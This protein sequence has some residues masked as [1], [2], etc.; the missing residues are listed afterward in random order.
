MR[1]LKTV[2]SHLFPIG[3][4]IVLSLGYF[5]PVLNGKA[6]FQ[7]D[8]V[9]FKGMQ[10]QVLEHR[11]DFEEEPYWIDNAFGG[12]PTYQIVSKHAHDLIGHI[13]GL[14]RFLPRPADY[15][16]VYLVGFYFLALFF[17]ASKPTAVMGAVAFGFSTYLIIILGVGHNTKALAIGYMPWA[18]LGV[19]HILKNNYTI[20]FPLA[21]LGTA[22]QLHANH[23]QMTY[24]MLLLMGVLVLFHV[25]RH[26]KNNSLPQLLRPLSMLVLSF[27]LALSFNATHLLAT[28]EYTTYST[29]G[30]NPLTIRADG[31]PS[32]DNE[33]LSYEYI[34]EYSY[35]ILESINLLVP[36]FMG[37]G[38]GDRLPSDSNL[39]QF[40]QKLEP[41]T[42]QQIFRYATPYWGNQPIVEAPAYVGAVV[43]FLALF[44]FLVMR[45]RWRMF[46]LTA[47]LMSLFLSWGKNADSLTHF[48]I[49][50]LPF[51]NKFRAV[52]SAQVILELCLPIAA[53]LGV[54]ALLNSDRQ[55]QLN[56]ALNKVFIG[57]M[58]F[59]GLILI[60]SYTLF[61][62]QSDT[63]AF[64]A[65]PEIMTPLVEDRKQLMMFDT[66]RSAAF[67]FIAF[68]LCRF[69]VS[70][71]YKM[72]VVP[73]LTLLI[74][75]DLWSF[76]RNYVNQ[77]D[78][79]SKSRI[80][81]PFVATAADLAIQRDTT[82]FRVFEPQLR[83]AHSRTAY[84]HNTLGGYHGAK[85]R[86]M[87]DL[88]DFH[89]AKGNDQ[90]LNML[91]VKYIIQEDPDNPLGVVRNPDSFGNAW[92]V[93]EVVKVD[94][95]ND[96][97]VGLQQTSLQT[98]ALTTDSLPQYMFDNDPQASIKLVH[99][100]ANSLVYEFVGTKTQF[101]VFSE[102]YYPHGWQAFIDGKSTNHYRVNYALRG[103][104]IPAGSSQITFKF[105]P[106][107]IQTGN[108]IRYTGY[109]VFSL[110]LVLLVFLPMFKNY[111]STKIG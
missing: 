63:E 57:L 89:L 43:F 30:D 35:G 87:Q 92:L 31:T 75:I 96:E 52:S 77:D 36:R 38:S 84:F 33:G 6:I 53:V 70:T 76:D 88:Y 47:S 48:L 105:V 94:S 67:V 10:R 58:I 101:A 81:Q 17:K 59:L 8:I 32:A 19:L 34:T 95:S 69:V 93:Q 83:M 21:V 26:I 64:A 50:Y 90:V 80:D 16:F 18:F 12:M 79:V 86:R 85:P 61:D 62:F 14:I 29:R 73:A 11:A 9:Q 25:I 110:L 78:F 72:Y 24:Y 103:L 56:K 108:Q 23:Y 7:S 65:Y 99:H 68:L 27:L 104:I 3:I 41:E 46:L 102:M 109:G 71:K 66:F 39:I 37:G 49:E 13:D 42:A 28:N 107:V 98:V 51:Y 74:I 111:N 45:K 55:D 100:Q 82:R 44:G 106:D 15:L 20:G 22:L 97:I 54:Q 40:L 4:F 1:V 5:Y 60:G 2:L 91:H